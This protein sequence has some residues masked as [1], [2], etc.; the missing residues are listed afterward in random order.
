MGVDDRHDHS[1]RVP[2]PDLSAKLGTPNACTACHSEESADWAA[3]T[4]AEWFGP[5]RRHE[6]RFGEA[7]HD[8]HEG[9]PGAV[10]HLTRLAGDIEQP[11]IARATGL[12]LFGRYPG[13]ALAEAVRAGSTDADPLVRLGALLATAG[14]AP[15]ER[16]ALVGGLLTDPVLGVRAEAAR[17]LAG[18]VGDTSPEALQ[19]TFEA[20]AAEFVATQNANAERPESHINLAVFYTDRGR[21][22]DAESEY[23]AAL[24]LDPGGIAASVNFADLRRVQ[25][26][27][28]DGERLLRDALRRWPQNAAARHAL[29]LTLIRLERR[30]E[31][32]L[33]LGRAAEWAPG[34]AR[35]GY[36]YGVALDSLGQAERAIEVLRETR[37]RHP[38]DRDVL[39]ALAGMCRQRGL[40]GEAAGY[41]RTLE[42]L[43]Y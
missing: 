18:S 36:V 16:T 35:H 15:E 34:V 25:G 38:Y 3:G 23:L 27:D 21:F 43:S 11:A 28:T 4:I 13:L 31:A 40:L 24:A 19:L 39:A 42:R 8:G 32:L 7:L 33:E 9:L 2:R 17:V 1:F 6:W 14:I 20:A 12:E 37:G 26:R 30:D 10:E 29:G 22:D 5:E 41:D